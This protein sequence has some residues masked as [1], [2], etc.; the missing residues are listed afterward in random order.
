MQLHIHFI[1]LNSEFNQSIADDFNNGEESEDNIKNLW[2]D[3][4]KVKEPVMD[5]KI[6][7][8]LPFLLKGIYPDKNTFSF[9]I[10]NVSLVEYT[11]QSG[12]KTQLA[13]SKKL[14]KNTDKKTEGNATHLY[15]Y[16]CDDVP[17]QNPYVGVY[18]VNS[19]FPKELKPQQNG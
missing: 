5:F 1:Q 10:P 19:D 17:F 6:K 2:E 9:E 13:V 18:I 12:E 4:L 3:E 16:L 15:F 7:H 14:I 11:T 8:N